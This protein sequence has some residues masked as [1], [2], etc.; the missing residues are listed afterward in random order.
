MN[1]EVRKDGKICSDVGDK[2]RRI[3]NSCTKRVGETQDPV[4]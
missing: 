2:L 1:V 4:V 3:I